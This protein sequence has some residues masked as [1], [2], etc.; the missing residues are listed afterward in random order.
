MGGGEPSINVVIDVAQ[1]VPKLGTFHKAEWQV[2][3]GNELDIQ[4]LQVATGDGLA[5]TTTSIQLMP[6]EGLIL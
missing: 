4:N 5:S 2:A 1:E 6:L 3:S